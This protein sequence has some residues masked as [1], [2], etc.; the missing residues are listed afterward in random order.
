MKEIRA[1][2]IEFKK[3]P[4][5]KGLT[6]ME[7]KKIDLVLL[8]SDTAGLIDK[9]ISHGKLNQNDKKNLNI[10]FK[11]L[12]IVVEKLKGNER[13]YFN[14]LKDMVNLIIENNKK[15]EYGIS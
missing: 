8:D 11:E 4:F 9:F 2:Y 5:P 7:I 14:I 13:E 3:I 6:G 15:N 10:C 1:K 12:L